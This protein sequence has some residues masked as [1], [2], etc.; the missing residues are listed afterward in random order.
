METPD[1]YRT[2]QIRKLMTTLF[3]E[4]ARGHLKTLAV[5]YGWSP[6]KLQEMEARFI[7]PLEMVPEFK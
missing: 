6:E 3:T 4:R 2:A 7:K 5:A 1:E